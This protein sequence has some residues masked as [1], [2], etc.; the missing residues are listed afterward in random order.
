MFKDDNGT[1]KNFKKLNTRVLTKILYS[2]IDNVK[3]K[4]IQKTR[5]EVQ[6]VKTFLVRELKKML[7]F[8]ISCRI[9]KSLVVPGY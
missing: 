8:N 7:F 1:Q 9:E 2:E 6:L 3:Y 5:K 4:F